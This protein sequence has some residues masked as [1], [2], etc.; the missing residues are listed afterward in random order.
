M[1]FVE[2][3]VE[4]GVQ[5]AMLQRARTLLMYV[6]GLSRPKFSFKVTLRRK[7][8][9]WTDYGSRTDACIPIICFA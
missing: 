1:A 3:G 2:S 8:G 7:F 9:D 4:T 5:F 6:L